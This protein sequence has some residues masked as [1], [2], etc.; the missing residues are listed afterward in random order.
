M[1]KNVHIS[2]V[3][4]L[5]VA[6]ACVSVPANAQE[7]L[8][9]VWAEWDPANYLAELS[10]DFTAET[11]IPVDVVQIPWSNFQDKVFTAFVGE[12]QALRHRHRR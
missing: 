5:I 12:K 1:M 6:L 9:I 3:F 4:V 11:G 10:K 8:T 7:S 2:L